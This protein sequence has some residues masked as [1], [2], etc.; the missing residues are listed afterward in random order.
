MRQDGLLCGQLPVASVWVRLR[1]WLCLSAGDGCWHVANMRWSCDDWL[2]KFAGAVGL[3]KQFNRVPSF[4]EH[5]LL[6]VTA[7][8]MPATVLLAHIASQRAMQFDIPM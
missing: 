7:H 1:V 4:D 6:V 3:A 2:A 8:S 5:M